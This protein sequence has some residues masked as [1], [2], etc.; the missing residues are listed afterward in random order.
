MQYPTEEAEASIP[1]ET[2]NS[3]RNDANN[4]TPTIKD[5]WRVSGKAGDNAATDAASRA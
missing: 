1:T 3:H 2:M 5:R 4:A